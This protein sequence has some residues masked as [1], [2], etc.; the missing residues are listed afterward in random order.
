VFDVGFQDVKS[1]DAPACLTVAELIPL[2]LFSC[3][4]VLTALFHGF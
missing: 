2:Q 1:F 3:P 4:R